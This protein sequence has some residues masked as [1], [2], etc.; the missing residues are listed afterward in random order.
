MRFPKVSE[1]DTTYSEMLVSD[2]FPGLEGPYDAAV[3]DET[4]K[5]TYFFVEE[6]VTSWDWSSNQI[7]ELNR[8][9]IESTMFSG[10]PGEIDAVAKYD[11]QF[12][13]FSGDEYYIFTEDAGVDGGHPATLNGEQIASAFHSFYNG[14]I[15]TTVN[16][17]TNNNIYNLVKVKA[18]TKP[19]S[20]AEEF[21]DAVVKSYYN[22]D[23]DDDTMFGWPCGLGFCGTEIFGNQLVLWD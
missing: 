2:K 8:A 21:Q 15:Y 16:S 5:V 22:I 20:T 18:I 7:G 3:T 19:V 4:K 23:M 12:I 1:P 9:P 10:L 11:D 13:F 14:Y 17:Y 6:T